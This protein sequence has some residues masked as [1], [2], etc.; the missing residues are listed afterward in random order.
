[1]ASLHP[2]S[3]AYMRDGR[4]LSLAESV[5]AE[6]MHMV[7]P[8]WYQWPPL[9]PMWFGIIGFVIA[10]LGTMSLAGNFIVMY[11][12]TSSK[13]LRTPSNMFVVNLAF[14][15]FMMMFTMFPPV[16]LNGFYGTWIMGP[17]LCELYGMFGSLFGCVSI[18]S[19]TLIAYD[20]YCVIVKGMARKPLTA[21]A[22]V[23]RLM[24]VWTICG[25]WA[26][27]PLFGWNRYVPEGNMT[28]CGT[29]YFAKDWWNRSYIIVYSLWVYLTPLLT[30][31]FSYWH[32]MKA[33][34][35]HEK[36]MREQAKKMNVASLRN[37]EADKSKA[38]EIKLAKV[39]LTTISLWF[40]AWTPYTIINYAGI[41]ESMHLSPLSTICGS[42]FAKA[43]A[44]CNP[45]VYGL[46]HPKYKQV[47]R[48]KMPC[49]ACGKDDLTSDSRTQATAEISESQA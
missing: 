6:I 48:E 40:F 24:V 17:F 36:A 21:T 37:S 43:N 35:A 41:F 20:R 5:P 46:S 27:M 2:P 14:S 12:F 7:D 31:I 11:I 26:L 16:V 1:M 34:A 18:W 45:I 22:A 30:I 38:I 47:L 28:A 29:D 13:G 39:A 3:F 8:Y 33:V 44:V 25:A 9:E 49:L 4:N 42:V 10:I 23:L 32:I 15:D 19:M